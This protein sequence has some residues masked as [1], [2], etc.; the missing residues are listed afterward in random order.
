[1]TNRRRR[2]RNEGSVHRRKDGLWEGKISL[3]YDA[4][5]RRI[6]PTVYGKT[7]REVLD[8]LRELQQ[9]AASGIPVK[10]GSITLS[11]HLETW[12]L[13][14]RD[15][16]KPSTL[17][18]YQAHA[19][20]INN[21]EYGI[22]HIRLSGLTYQQIVHFYDR[23]EKQAQLAKRTIFDV[24]TTL[25]AVLT[26][27]VNK[28]VIKENPALLVTRSKGE[29]EAAFM[30]PDQL[31]ALLRAVKAERLYD[32]FVVL[33]NTGLRPGEWLGLAWDDVDLEAATIT[34]RQALHEH[35]GTDDDTEGEGP[36]RVIYLGPV[37]TKASRR[38]ITLPRAAVDALKRWR[39][40]QL[41][42]RMQAGPRWIES[43]QIIAASVLS[44]FKAKTDLVFT[45]SVGGFMSRTNILRR[46]L[47]RAKN[48]AAV[49][50]AAQ[51][52]GADPETT[53]RINGPHLPSS[54]AVDAGYR[55]VLPDGR[56]AVLEE[57]DLLNDVTLHTFRHTHA[58][59][60]IAAKVDIKTISTR[61]GH[62]RISI[63]YDLY[64]HLLPG[65]DEEAANYMDQF[66]ASV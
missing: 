41:E 7:K 56:Q 3:G 35:Q 29:T 57:K 5:G 15:E 44:G 18:K 8:K 24:S 11:S 65:M 33:A 6:R 22:G 66:M 26:D 27:A 13:E 2:G 60:L 32:A 52:L 53:L 20:H 40:R 30:T 1:M 16:L 62:E 23:L 51:R 59:M 25:R 39:R 48:R 47:R 54:V 43:Q 55:I 31:R 49:I 37:K 50:L 28:K 19:K 17:A 63:T 58:S 61:L 64:G 34:V 38:T 10:P 42:E 21:R 46:D 4:A 36:G 45:N 12:L 9:D 14:K